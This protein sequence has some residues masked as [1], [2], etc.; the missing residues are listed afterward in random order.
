MAVYRHPQNVDGILFV[1]RHLN[2][3]KAV[4][5]YDRAAPKLGRAFYA[6]LMQ[7]SAL[8]SAISNLRIS[9]DYP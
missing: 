3:R 9:F 8:S 1:S 4:V 5:V 2:D 7:A 6:S